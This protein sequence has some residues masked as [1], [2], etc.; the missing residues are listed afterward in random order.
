MKWNKKN[1]RLFAGGFSLGSGRNGGQIAQIV[2]FAAVGDGFEVLRISAVGDADTGDLALLCHIH[3]LLFFHNGIVRK[4]ISG[5]PAALFY[6]TDNSFCI[7]FGLRDLIQCIFDEIMIL[8]FCITPF[9]GSICMI[10]SWYTINKEYGKKKVSR[11]MQTILWK[12]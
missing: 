4:L 3:S 7:G 5:D 12:D 6:K 9:G 11:R 8:H 2:V 10:K 1:L